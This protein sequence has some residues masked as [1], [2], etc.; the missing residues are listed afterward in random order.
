MHTLTCNAVQTTHHA[1]IIIQQWWQSKTMWKKSFSMKTIYWG[2]DDFY[3]IIVAG[4]AKRGVPLTSNSMNLEDWNLCFKALIN[5][6][7]SPSIKLCYF[8]PNFMAMSIFNRKLWI[9]NVDK[10]DVC[11]RPL[12]TNPVT[13]INFIGD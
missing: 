11:R 10:L 4:F 5:L 13:I 12:F 8:C 6:K 1:N 9:V 3:Y 2:S 7:F